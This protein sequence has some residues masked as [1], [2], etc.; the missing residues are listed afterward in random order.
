[1]NN[2]AGKPA[3]TVATQPARNITWEK[4][5]AIPTLADGSQV[6]LDSLGNGVIATQNGTQVVLK[7]GALA[8]AQ[9][10]G[11]AT[12]V[13]NHL[14]TAKG[15]QFRLVLPDGTKVWLNAASSLKYPTV[16]DGNQRR[17]EVLGEVFFEGSAKLS[18]AF[19]YQRQQPGADPRAGNA[20]QCKCLCQ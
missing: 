20:V 18:S 10:A 1:M 15:R 3:G 6:V 4:D 5:G 12:P 11:K 16:F 17:V 19:P 8:Y 14:S 13:Y 9:D 7:N 2:K